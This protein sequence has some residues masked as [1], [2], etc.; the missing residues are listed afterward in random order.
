MQSRVCNSWCPRIISKLDLII[1]QDTNLLIY[2]EIAIRLFW[3]VVGICTGLNYSPSLP[4][5]KSTNRK[6]NIEGKVYNRKNRWDAIVDDIGI[7]EFR[8]VSP[9][10]Y[11]LI[12][13]NF[14]PKS[15]VIQILCPG[16]IFCL[17]IQ[18]RKQNSLA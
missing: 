5:G 16:D 15:I 17:E 8:T 13:S 6:I 1:T 4:E 3:T 9:I 11:Y 2:D 12:S 10:H 18:P 7:K 14:R